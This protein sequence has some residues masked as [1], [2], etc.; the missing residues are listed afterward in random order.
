MLEEKTNAL[1]QELEEAEDKIALGNERIK[2]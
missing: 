2:S 1:V